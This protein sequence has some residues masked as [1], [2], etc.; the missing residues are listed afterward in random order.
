MKA[1]FA[2]LL[3]LPA[4]AA[5]GHGE[6]PPSNALD[7]ACAPG[8]RHGPTG[9]MDWTCID[10]DGEQRLRPRSLHEVIEGDELPAER[11]ARE[12]G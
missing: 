5:C 11:E 8:G 12:D 6:P 1:L 2:G 9:V 7:V 3:V 4:L 10:G